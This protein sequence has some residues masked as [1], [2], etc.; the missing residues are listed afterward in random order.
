MSQ[1]NFNIPISIFEG[2]SF[3]TLTVPFSELS[4]YNQPHADDV[5]IGPNHY[6]GKFLGYQFELVNHDS[7]FCGYVKIDK[8]SELGKI[9]EKLDS[10]EL[11]SFLDKNFHS[12]MGFTYARS[13]KIGFDCAHYDYVTIWPDVRRIEPKGNATYK[14]YSFVRNEC[15][16]TIESIF[17]FLNRKN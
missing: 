15:M 13:D 10:D 1:T 8:L 3:K 16:C 5:M 6:G 4:S 2:G 7:H 14:T 9:L 12:Y 17:S 11:E